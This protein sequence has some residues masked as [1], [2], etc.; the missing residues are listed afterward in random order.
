MSNQVQRRMPKK[1]IDKVDVRSKRVLARVDFNVPL[2]E[3][4]PPRITDDR[5]IRL[6]LPTIESVLGRSGRLILMSHLGRPEGSGFEPDFSLKP[7]A[8]RLAELLPGVKVMFPDND[9]IGAETAKA[10]S[11]MND[12]DVVVLENLRFH[13]GEKKGDPDFAAKLASF[14][15]IYCNDAFGTAHRNDAS[16]FAVPKVMAGKPRVAGLLM[17]KELKFLS[18]AIQNARKP[19]IAVLGGAKVS[20]KLGAMRNLMGKVDTILVGGAMAYTFLKALGQEVGSSLVQPDMMAE[21]CSII[22]AAAAS[23]TDLLLPQDHV[24]GTQISRFT[25]VKVHEGGIP[26]G[27]MGLDIGPR[28][29][30]S[31]AQVI[32]GGKTIVWNGPMGV[33]ETTPFDVGTRQIAHA[34]ARAT[35][36]GATTIVGGGDSAAAV[37]AFGIAEQFSHV[38]TGGGASLEML[39]GKAF[40]SVALLDDA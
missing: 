18:E 2:D 12:R 11:A 6:A 39:E 23:K 36:A 30:A 37:E 7:A 15:D 25:P 35:K 40:D 34:V 4:D 16:M 26:Q 27:W 24:C 17:H 38:S 19:F 5:R 33:F 1:T 8:D 9:C 21:A 13:K 14:G 31:Y 28:T 22:D 32:H 10:V 29:T 3:S 20:D